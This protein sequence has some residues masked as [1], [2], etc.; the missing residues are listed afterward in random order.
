MTRRL[1]GATTLLNGF[2]VML[3]EASSYVR[4][5]LQVVPP[6]F[7][8]ALPHHHSYRHH[9]SSC[10]SSTLPLLTKTTNTTNVVSFMVL[11][12]VRLALCRSWHLCAL[13]FSR[14]V[15]VV[16]FHL[17]LQL[18]L[19]LRLLHFFLASLFHPLPQS[20]ALPNTNSVPT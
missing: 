2:V 14:N 5:S 3:L 7:N 8:A 16:A 18:F 17:D 15:Q 19:S 13:N 9:L 1:Y 10:L 12:A 11:T 4:K 6:V 20:E